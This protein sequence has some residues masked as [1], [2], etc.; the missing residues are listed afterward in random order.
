MRR[1]IL[2]KQISISSIDEILVSIDKAVAGDIVVYDKNEDNIKIIS[3]QLSKL[4]TTN[5]SNAED[6]IKE[7]VINYT[8][9]AVVA[10]PN[11]TKNSTATVRAISL[12]DVA[13]V[14]PWGKTESNI[15]NSI[16]AYN[17]PYTTLSG[18]INDTSFIKEGYYNGAYLPSNAYS[19]QECIYDPYAKYYGP[20]GMCRDLL[21]YGPSPYTLRGFNSS[22]SD[23]SNNNAL[24]DLN[25][26]TN[27]S[28]ILVARG[29][30]TTPSTGT[31]T[32]PENHFLPAYYCNRYSTEGLSRGSWYLGAAGEFGYVIA[33]MK[34]IDL[35]LK[36]IQSIW[37]CAV[38]E[39]AKQ[40]KAPLY[41]EYEEYYWTSSAYNT[42]IATAI[43]PITGKITTTMPRT[44]YCRIRA[45]TQISNSDIIIP[46]RPIS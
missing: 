22:Y 35:S 20:N 26:K 18:V 44:E 36:I 17:V 38:T 28:N 16:S 13:E 7:L 23:S 39:I 9:V 43:N 30:I 42:G 37:G 31:I 8:P 10:V 2:F 21:Y 27:T 19:C 46:D 1:R 12:T 6:I 11:I 15:S 5:S 4:T 41:S 32:N 40:V 29:S 3:T 34:T 45:F 14:Y 24:S 25:G 33:R